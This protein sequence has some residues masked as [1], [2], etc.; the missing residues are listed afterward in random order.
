MIHRETVGLDVG[1]H[2]AKVVRAM[3]IGGRLIV[4]DAAWVHLPPDPSER[5]RILAAFLADKGYNAVPSVLGLSGRDLMLN[6][7]ELPVGDPRSVAEVAAL[8]QERVEGLTEQETASDHVAFRSAGHRY[9][10]LAMARSEAVGRGAAMLSGLGAE[11]GDIVPGSMALYRAVHE[12]GRPHL[13]GSTMCVDIGH[14]GAEVVV[15]RGSKV[16]FSR[17]LS[18]GVGGALTSGPVSSM[19]D[20]IAACLESFHASFPGAAFVVKRVVLSGGG[21]LV[22]G[23]PDAIGASTGLE[24]IRLSNWVRKVPVEEVER[25]GRAIG[26]AACGVRRGGAGISLLPRALRESRILRWQKQYWILSSAA[27]IILMLLIVAGTLAELRWDNESLRL[28]QVELEGLRALE[29]KLAV[30]DRLNTGLEAQIAPFRTAIK[31]AEILK[32]ALGAIAASKH[33]DDWLSLLADADAYFDGARPDE[34]R[35]SDV[36]PHPLAVGFAQVILE[37]YTPV[38][39]FSTV[40]TMIDELRKLAGIVDAD[41]LGDERLRDDPARDAR[42]ADTGCSLFVVEMTVR[43]P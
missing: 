28:R 31:N 23:V 35:S 38:D 29:R 2:S 19:A 9:L 37:G 10:L 7:V 22:D 30:Y 4:R 11:V 1:S 43:T 8:E 5:N 3:R 6:V 18:V 34:E 40:G 27:L 39:D 32:V 21:A 36:S 41:L 26:L 17:G 14:A 15:G 24:T 12:L 25:Y 13:S 16:L 42:W 20:E 33:P